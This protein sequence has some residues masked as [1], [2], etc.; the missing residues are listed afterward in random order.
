MFATNRGIVPAVRAL[1]DYLAEHFKFRNDNDFK[2]K[3]PEAARSEEQKSRLA[4]ATS[5][6][7]P[8]EPALLHL[9]AA[10]PDHIRHQLSGGAQGP[11]PVQMLLQ[12]GGWIGEQVAPGSMS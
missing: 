10:C 4:K 1:T 6:A 8:C 3:K 2:K 11:G 7:R 12:S 5:L 9:A